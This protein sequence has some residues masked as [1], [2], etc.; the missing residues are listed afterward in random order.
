MRTLFSDYIYSPFRSNSWWTDPKSSPPPNWRRSSYPWPCPLMKTDLF[1]ASM[2]ALPTRSSHQLRLAP[3]CL[4][5][6]VDWLHPVQASVGNQSCCEH[7]D[8]S[9]VQEIVFTQVSLTSG[10][11]SLSA[12]SSAMFPEP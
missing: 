8:S 11:Y 3:V 9:R 12:P 10:S 4:W 1:P 7:S 5:G 6:N 2:S